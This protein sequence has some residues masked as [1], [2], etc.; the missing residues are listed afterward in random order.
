VVLSSY[1]EEEFTTILEGA[2]AIFEANGLGKPTSFRAGGWSAEI[3]TLKALANAGYVADTSAVN[4][5]RIEEWD[6]VPGASLYEW[7][8]THWA[9]MGDT[10]QPYYPSEANILEPGSPAVPVLEVP[11]NGALVDYVSGDE[12]IEIFRANW[13][14]GALDT[15]RQFSIGYHPPNYS[16]R[17]HPRMMDILNH[18]DLNLAETGG[19][20][21]VYTTL[22]DLVQVWPQ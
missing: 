22:S 17:Y 18:V 3:N 14:G 13:P 9:P 7:L 6:G 12:M 8:M 15:P 16:S 20:P 11:D 21:A 5:A 19:G 2:D 1:T 10:D 4:W